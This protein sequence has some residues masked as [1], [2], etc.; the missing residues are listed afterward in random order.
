MISVISTFGGWIRVRIVPPQPD[1]IGC[2]ETGHEIPGSPPG[3]LGAL[4]EGEAVLR[5]L[6]ELRAH[7]QEGL[8]VRYGALRHPIVGGDLLALFCDLPLGEPFAVWELPMQ[9]IE[10]VQDLPMRVGEVDH[11]PLAHLAKDSVGDRV[12]VGR[13]LDRYLTGG[14]LQEEAVA[15]LQPR[16]SRH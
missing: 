5:L 10:G 12:V 7:Y 8:V 11:G 3:R 13:R 9:V 16:V 4:D 6:D 15:L 14:Q 2:G 1:L